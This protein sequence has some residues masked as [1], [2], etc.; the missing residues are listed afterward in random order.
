MDIPFGRLARLGGVYCILLLY[1]NNGW[2]GSWLYD[3]EQFPV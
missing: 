2:I 1:G 3:Q